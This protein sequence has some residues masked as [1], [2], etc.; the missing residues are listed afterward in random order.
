MIMTPDEPSS[1]TATWQD[2]LDRQLLRHL[3]RRTQEPGLTRMHLATFI[4]TRLQRMAPLPL[5]AEVTRR[6]EV[7]DAG[8]TQ[9][10][11]VYVQ[12]RQ[13]DV[14]AGQTLMPLSSQ[15]PLI[16]QA[17]FA[18]RTPR[19]AEPP[20]PDSGSHVAPAAG[21]SS[22]L[23]QSPPVMPQRLPAAG[24][25]LAESRRSLAD[26]RQRPAAPTPVA[27]PPNVQAQ[28]VQRAMRIAEPPGSDGGSHAASFT[29][30]AAAQ[31]PLMAPQPQP[32]RS[33]LS[34]ADLPQPMADRHTVVESR[35]AAP[36]DTMAPAPRPG[37]Q[38]P[39][40]QPL[41]VHR[42]APPADWLPRADFHQLLAGHHT[43]VER[44]GLTQESPAAPAP[45]P[46]VQPRIHRVEAIED[47]PDSAMS[48]VRAPL[49]PQ[50]RR[51]SEGKYTDTPGHGRMPPSAPDT[52]HRTPPRPIVPE[53]RPGTAPGVPVSMILA[54]PALPAHGPH[55]LQAPYEA[56]RPVD[57]RPP[58][59]IGNGRHDTIATQQQI[60]PSTPSVPAATTP[61]V[62]SPSVQTQPTQEL[63]LHALAAKV[64]HALDMDKLVEQVQR[65]LRRRLT[66]ESERRG[67]SRW[68]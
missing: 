22:P 62:S 10:P 48:I 50:Q 64:H 13:E 60:A 7:E 3:W 57:G 23:L 30:S 11:I 24:H 1:H 31:P 9:V 52:H 61:S 12:P 36:Q 44:H 34:H 58:P 8:G 39:S 40:V 32:V 43:V 46:V 51:E 20:G 49:S 2:A 67:W 16:V 28:F 18:E 54:P 33:S 42:T 47:T 38:A 56:S 65:Q 6:H 29:E 63:N 5:L 19:M 35:R 66:I 17:Q 55:V 53:S 41:R 15:Q 68:T 45:R 37:A 25:T 27:H 26:L 14:A 59:H 4:L 21:V